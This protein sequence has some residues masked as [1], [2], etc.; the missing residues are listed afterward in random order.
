MTAFVTGGSGAIGSAI[1]LALSEMGYNVAV[2]YNS[3]EQKAQSIAGEIIK[4]GKKAVAVKCDVT[5]CESV[6]YAVSEC[7]KYLGELDLLV[8]NAGIADINLFTHVSDE[9]M[10]SIVSCNL[11]GAMYASRAVLPQMINR[12]SG[13]IINISSMWGEVGASCEVVYSAA[14]AG[15]IGFTKALAKEVGLSGIR[16]NCITAGMID[17]PMNKGFTQDEISEIIQEIPLSRMGTPEDIANAV[18]FLASEK[19]SYVTGAILKVNGGMCI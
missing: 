1:C 2:G 17:T 9:K 15:L 19:A 8:N 11:M 6:N 18:T 5:A 12:K 13:N 10:Q 14:K 7:E 3:N 4:N 16:V